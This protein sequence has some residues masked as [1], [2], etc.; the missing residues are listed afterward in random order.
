MVK[1][2]VCVILEDAGISNY[3]RVDVEL[4]KT[5]VLHHCCHTG[6]LNFAIR[7]INMCGHRN[8]HF[9]LIIPVTLTVMNFNNLWTVYNLM[10][11]ASH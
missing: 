4:Y 6:H 10:N 11:R 1:Y 9:I 7:S 8:K 3:Y 5:L 2:D